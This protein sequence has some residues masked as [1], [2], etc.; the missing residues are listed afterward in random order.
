MDTKRITV[1]LE[2]A[3]QDALSAFADPERTEHAALAAW[4]QE[5]GLPL[6]G[7]EAAIVR[8]LV[9]AGVEALQEKALE[10][11]YTRLAAELAANEDRQAERKLRRERRASRNESFPS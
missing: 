5:R 9:R 1:T 11:G 8:A 4:A 6:K 2:G 7:S 10:L 3:E